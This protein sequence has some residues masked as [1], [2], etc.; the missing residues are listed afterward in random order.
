MSAQ[1]DWLLL[2]RVGV[3]R[4]ESRKNSKIKGGM[5]GALKLLLFKLHSNVP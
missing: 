1:I 5:P 3:S 4:N 2:L